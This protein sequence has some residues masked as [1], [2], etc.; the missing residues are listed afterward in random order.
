MTVTCNRHVRVLGLAAMC[1]VVLFACATKAPNSTGPDEAPEHAQADAGSPFAGATVT[2]VVPFSPGG[3]YDSYAR[4]LAPYLEEELDA[5]RV[6]VENQPG[7]GGLL[8]IN[9][10]RADR[11]EGLRIALMNGIGVAGAATAGAEGADFALDDLTYVGRVMTG[12]QVWVAGTRSDRDSFEAVRSSSG[13][14]F[15]SSGPGASDFVFPTLLIAAL[16]LDAE[17]VTGFD[18]SAEAEL[19]VTRGDVDGYVGDAQGRLGAIE[20]GEHIALLSLTADRLELFPDAP[21]LGELELTDTQ[22]EIVDGLFALMEMG[23]P[24]VAPPGV[25]EANLAALRNAL[26]RALQRPELLEDAA[27]ADRPIVPLTGEEMD[28]VVRRVMDAPQE[29][30]AA[31]EAA[32]GS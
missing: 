3:G 27:A 29:F 30:R 28:D 7:A 13:F 23:R 5:A 14:R 21:A 8:A 15:A 11:S 20:D 10:L 1:A 4:M 2:L 6:V 26:A 17:I 19:A 16:D 18:G 25:P 22:R 12:P 32:Y 24:I 31:L 9:Q